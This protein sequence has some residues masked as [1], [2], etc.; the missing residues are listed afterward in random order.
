MESNSTIDRGHADNGDA[1]AGQGLTTGELLLI[2][3]QSWRLVIGGALAA[4]LVALGITFLLTPIFTARTVIMPPQQQQSGA[5]AALSSLG[6]LAGLAGVGAGGG[7]PAEQYLALLQSLTIAD[8]IIDHFNLMVVYDNKYRVL[9]Q[10]ELAGNVRVS[11]GKKDGLITIEV[12]DTDA[13]RS[14]A[15]A[16]RYVEEL[17]LLTNTLAVSEAQQRRVFFEQ[18][19]QKSKEGLIRAQVELQSSGFNSGAL[20]AEPRATAETYARMLAELAAGEIRLQT[21]K[22]SLTENSP[23]VTQLRTAL[24]ALRR[25]LAGLESSAQPTG[26]ADYIGRYR[27]FKYQET[28]FELMARQ[29]ELARVDESREGALIQ[30]LDSASPPELKSK[31]KRGI[32]ATLATILSGVILST[33]TVLR[34]SKK[35]AGTSSALRE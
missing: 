6:A 29:Y 8:R 25:Q 22:S 35:L 7:N 34:R 30:V 23:D 13:K 32:I 4:G 1:S 28:L 21:L 14:S 33:L 24:A 5:A 3:V 12:D 2:L 10:K 31:P 11:V 26:N 18:Q 19:L 17:R 20:K 16:N 15:I 9:T 27:E